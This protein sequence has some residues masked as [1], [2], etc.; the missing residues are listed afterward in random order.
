MGPCEFGLLNAGWNAISPDPFQWNAFLESIVFEE[1]GMRSDRINRLARVFFF[2]SIWL[3]RGP[4][5]TCLVFAFECL[6]GQWA[7]ERCL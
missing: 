2:V 5:G 1:C 6:Y 4:I 7:V 3:A